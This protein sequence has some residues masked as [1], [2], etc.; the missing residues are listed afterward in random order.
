MPLDN[1]DIGNGSLQGSA[2]LLLGNKSRDAPVNLVGQKSLGP[3]GHEPQ[4]IVETLRDSCIR[5]YF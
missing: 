5:R 2:A 1:R 3:N 4:N